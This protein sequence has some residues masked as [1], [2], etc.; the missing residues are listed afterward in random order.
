MKLI[1]VDSLDGQ[2]QASSQPKAPTQ[3]SASSQVR[4]QPQQKR[5]RPKAE[6]KQKE[7]DDTKASSS[8]RQEKSS[9]WVPEYTSVW[10]AKQIEP[11]PSSSIQPQQ[12][13]WSQ[14]NPLSQS[15]VHSFESV[16]PPAPSAWGPKHQL[17][18][19]TP[20]SQTVS[21]P[22]STS[23]NRNKPRPKTDEKTMQGEKKAASR[24]E[25]PAW[26]PQ[27]AFDESRD[28]YSD[29]PKDKPQSQQGKPRPTQQ[30]KQQQRGGDAKSSG[31]E[32]EFDKMS[33]SNVSV[34][35]STSSE[36]SKQS[37]V[38]S[39]AIPT[40]ALIPLTGNKGS[41]TIGRKVTVDVNFLPLLIE[42]L[43]PKVYQYDVTIE[44]N[45]PKRMLPYI[46]ESYRQKNF[47]N[48]YVAFDGNKIAVSPKIL[49]IN[50]RI[51][52]QTKVI[53]ENG[54]ERVYMVSMK[55]ARDSEIN[56]QSLKK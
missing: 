54:R 45:L 15:K 44:P 8:S 38:P 26:V 56:F 10:G 13:A 27:Y 22:Q 39:S 48:I 17:D 7:L 21:Q 30:Q 23:S 9:A 53:D 41:G 24:Q 52:K 11:Q 43:L 6:E 42:K 25:Q 5:P 3:P 51:E 18:S 20:S 14:S 34:T 35:S 29:Q 1:F 16:K 55:E 47:K 33:L 49:P 36:S 19:A 32:E 28:T 46:F 50:D 4:S 2:P 37:T 40:T 12:S 31:V